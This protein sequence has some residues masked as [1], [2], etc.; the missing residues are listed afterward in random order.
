MK[1]AIVICSHSGNTLKLGEMVSSQLM[2]AGHEVNL[3]SLASEPPMDPKKAVMAQ[4][5]T[6][7]NLPDLS[8]VDIVIIGGPVWAFRPCPLLLKAMADIGGQIK[9]KK[10]L[11]FVTQSFPFACM[12]GNSSVKKLRELAGR[13]G[14]KVL[15]GIVLAGASKPKLDH[16][17]AT[18]ARICAL[19]Q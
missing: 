17:T 2:E 13:A 7:T 6:I 12:G 18:A 8:S 4:N 5:M 15:P 3:D 19:I 9:G 1:V 14:A 10:V 11:P 16:Y